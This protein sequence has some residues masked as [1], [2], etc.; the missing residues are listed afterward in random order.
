MCGSFG[1]LSYVSKYSLFVLFDDDDH[2][3]S[4]QSGHD[5]KRRL[6]LFQIFVGYWSFHWVS[7]DF[8]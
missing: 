5:N 8:G 3:M 2:A 6:V 1:S 7:V 4:E